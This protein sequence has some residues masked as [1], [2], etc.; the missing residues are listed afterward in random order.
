MAQSLSFQWMLLIPGRVGVFWNKPGIPNFKFVKLMYSSVT[1][2]TL[3][4][5]TC[6]AVEQE[7]EQSVTKALR[8]LT[9]VHTRLTEPPIPSTGPLQ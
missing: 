3:T 7:V 6:L 1:L 2:T 8:N 9:A 5:E 4:L